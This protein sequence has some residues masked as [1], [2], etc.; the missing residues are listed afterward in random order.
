MMRSIGKKCYMTQHITSPDK[1]DCQ[2]YGSNTT[3]NVNC[4]L[5]NGS[6]CSHQDAGMFAPECTAI[7]HYGHKEDPKRPE[8][9]INFLISHLL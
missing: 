7:L 6:L 4:Y 9:Q 5:K 8:H 2:W 3:A 1:Q